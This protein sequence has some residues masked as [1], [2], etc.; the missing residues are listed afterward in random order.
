LLFFCVVSKITDGLYYLNG[1]NV[2]LGGLTSQCRSLLW[3]CV[4]PW[5]RVPYLSALEMCSR[6][7]AIQIHDSTFTFTFTL[8]LHLLSILCVDRPSPPITASS[9]IMLTSLRTKAAV[10]TRVNNV[11][12]L[13]R[14]TASKA[15]LLVG[16]VSPFNNGLIESITLLLNVASGSVLAIQRFH[17]QRYHYILSL[18]P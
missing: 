3:N 17:R 2:W 6:R 15:F 14:E 11:S 12:V 13:R 7:G 18:S 1:I 8:P 16:D 4:I 9:N 10:Y 5:E